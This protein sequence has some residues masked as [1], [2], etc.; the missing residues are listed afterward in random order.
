[1]NTTEIIENIKFKKKQLKL[2]NLELSEKSGVKLGTLNKILSFKTGS[3]KTVTLNK[4]LSA[5][6]GDIPS[7]HKSV[8]DNFGFIKVATVTPLVDV[9]NVSF[10]VQKIIDG[11]E[12][13][14]KRGVKIVVFPE[15]CLTG[16]TVGDLVFQN[17]LLNA[18]LNGLN[19]IIKC[20]KDK[21][22]LIFVGMPI[23]SCNRLYNV[24]V[25]ILNGEILG[26]VPKTRL[27]SEERRYFSSVIDC[28]EIN[29]FGK[30]YPFSKNLI[31]T[32]KSIPNLSVAVELGDELYNGETASYYANN[33][34]TVIVNLSSSNELVGR[35]EYR[36]HAIISKTAY[37]NLAYVYANAG[38]GEST[39][40]LVF[41]GHS[42]IC[43]NGNILAESEPFKNST[44]ITDVDVDFLSFERSKK[45][46]EPL[47]TPCESVEFDLEIDGVKLDRRY[48]EMPFVPSVDKD[49]FELILKMQ[50]SALQKRINH[51]KPKTLVLG[52]SGGLDSTLAL[53]VAVRAMRAENRDL[54]DILAITMPCFGT[55]K[56]T[57]N[58]ATVLAEA[59]GVSFKEINIKNS[60]IE[61]F[62][63]IEHD[64]TVTDVTYENAQAR[65]RTQVLMD[66]ANKTGGIVLGTGDLSELAL[67]W[68]TYNGD[69]MS[70][71]SLNSSVPKTLIRYLVD[72][73]AGNYSKVIKETLKDVLSTPVSPE[74]IPP[75][76]GEISQI[77][78]DIVGPYLLHD[79]YLYYILRCGF[80]PQ[81]TYFIAKKTFNGRFS[82]EE[83]KKWL[84]NFYNRF[85]SQQFK[86]SCMPDGVKIGSV[87]L[88]PRGDLIMPSDASKAT[89]IEELE[90]L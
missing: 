55:T 86:R 32:S 6:D 35:A 46:N 18:S 36:R 31:F 68:A 62:K 87:G 58:N 76:D 89:F 10:N 24:A 4:I 72:Y 2:T 30:A 8:K 64:Q 20:S 82:D 43:E 16:S 49:R 29:F 19:Q 26:F 83:L 59:F 53:L 13:A 80:T 21:E 50:A 3:I 23:K 5:L 85:F 17:V 81:K 75:K 61:H 84:K 40:N 63:D 27:S 11:I 57:K 14:D 51:V 65:E 77:T 39:T 78:E 48:L 90:S 66:V 41:S 22:M 47:L 28:G 56:R 9:G 37:N 71:Y 74:L 44:L 54:K 33:G 38:F 52:L 79:F 69:H 67:G 1:M 45:S 88:S 42:I 25:C 15:L 7:S 12:G 34:A 70:M 60:V 73:E